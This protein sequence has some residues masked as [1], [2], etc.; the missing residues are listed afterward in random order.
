MRLMT[1]GTNKW[2]SGRPWLIHTC[3]TEE[4]VKG[5]ETAIRTAARNRGMLN[6]YSED[7]DPMDWAGIAVCVHE[8]LGK[9]SPYGAIYRVFDY[10]SGKLS[11]EKFTLLSLYRTK[12]NRPAVEEPT[13]E[14]P[15]P[16]KSVPPE[17]A[18]MKRGAST[19]LVGYRDDEIPVEFASASIGWREEVA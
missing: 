11:D 15:V 18:Q 12:V 3:P 7:Y 2:L 17:W 5:Y 19:A 4:K 6:I 9:H 14:E 16:A 1:E 8:D 13:V 10:K